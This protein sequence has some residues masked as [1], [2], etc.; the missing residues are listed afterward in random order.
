MF[1]DEDKK[2]DSFGQNI[3]REK[4]TLTKNII[5]TCYRL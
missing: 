4:K 3:E 5:S 1:H 2:S